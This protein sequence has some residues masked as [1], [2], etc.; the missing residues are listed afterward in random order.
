MPDTSAEEGDDEADDEADDEQ[1][2]ESATGDGAEGTGAVAS[3]ATGPL[4]RVLGPCGAA[5]RD[6][7]EV[8]L[9][10]IQRTILARLALARPG[11]VDTEELVDAVWADAPPASART[12]IHNQISRIRARLGSDAIVTDAGRYALRLST[13]ADLVTTSPEEVEVLLG[14]GCH[15][16][17]LRHASLALTHWRGVP[18]E[19][20][21]E[22]AA[23]HNARARLTETRRSLETLRLEALLGD[24]RL[25]TAIPEAERLVA[26]TPTDEH[27][28]VLL[29]RALELAGRRGDAL[30]AYERARR[31]LL[32]DFGI[33]PGPELRAAEAS[34]LE[35]AVGEMVN[36]P[37]PLVGRGELI[38]RALALCDAG[39]PVVLI[40]E[41]GIGKSRLL[42]ELRRRLRRR[43]AQVATS[44]CSLH[45]DEAVATLTD[46]LEDLDADLDPSLPPMA[47]FVAAVT[48][49]AEQGDQVVLMVDDLD[50]AGP[51]SVAAL[52]DAAEVEGVVL[53]ATAG[54]AGLVPPELSDDAL[55]VE[56]LGTT[57][58]EELA[59]WLIGDHD[60]VDQPRLAWLL[61]MSG[62]NPL[63]LEHMLADP[64]WPDGTAEIDP[65]GSRGPAPPDTLR[66]AVRRRVDRLG[67]TTRA[68]L[69]V[70]A[71]CGP[72]CPTD[73]LLGLAPQNGLAGAIAASLLIE[74]QDGDGQGWISFRHGA[75]LRTL[76]D[77]LSPGHR[78][79]IHHRAGELL[80]GRGGPLSSVA[81]HA[82]ASAEV[83]PATAVEDA[84]AAAR[85]ASSKGAHADAARWHERALSAIERTD[86]DDHLRVAS[87][88]GFA[89]SLRLAGAPEQQDAL[90]AAVDAAFALGDE[91]LIGDAA[92]AVLQLG[93]TTESG[94]L[95]SRSIDIAGRALASVTEPD[96]R[97]LIAAAASLAHSMTG[98]SA[99]CRELF[100]Q[101]EAAAKSPGTRRQVLPFAYLG[102]GHP[103]D[104]DLRER[105][106]D[107]LIGA[108]R[109]GNDPIALFEGLQLSFSVGLLR[110]DGQRVRASLEE[111]SLLVDRVGDVGRRWSLAYQRAAVA[112]LDGDLEAAEARSKEALELFASVSPSRA[113]AT[114]GAQILMIRLAQGR[115]EELIPTME[116]LMAEQPGVPAWHAALALAL[117]TLEP[118][119]ARRHARAA[120]EDVPEDFTWLAAHIIGG[121]A[122]S[123]VGDGETARRYLVALAPYSG[124]GCWQGTCSYGPVDTVIAQLHSS[125]GDEALAVE[126][127]ERALAQSQTLGAPVFAAELDRP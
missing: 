47:G 21:S 62:G 12:S 111:A 51:T 99:L 126:H 107:E 38:A 114:F 58:L 41:S 17:A 70:A 84:F 86:A 55:P 46:L 112:H 20:L 4:V 122:A 14:E 124:L 125:L 44:V 18:Y 32:S 35:T 100:L 66:E 117:A 71:V 26:D 120:L 97:A 102:L 25:A 110:C 48:E 69:E 121:R 28:W 50:R 95:H 42:E 10:M 96:Q 15:A 6:G 118:D 57:E 127:G 56:P 24:G 91:R 101:A 80:R 73:V 87:L 75:V 105:I 65:V 123:M 59:D 33:D 27:R 103:R 9:S 67:A 115:L 104:I 45:P 109:A 22:T 5:D 116:D 34:V 68:T 94:L 63:I 13:D 40:G 19:D 78:M 1:D 60:T 106:T 30:G 8:R 49:L 2:G 61:E 23:A 89:D 113:T 29:I 74:D 108:A 31:R 52:Q 16:E 37:T 90:F 7:E 64:A 11:Q 92:F 36:D 53:V 72:R 82:L 79:E 39:G 81:I 43:G 76:Y 83:D 119:R 77:D 3:P 88:I 85:S 93:A 54:D 98:D